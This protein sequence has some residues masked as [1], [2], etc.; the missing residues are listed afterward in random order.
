MSNTTDNTL[1]TALITVPQFK[2]EHTMS[3]AEMETK[4]SEGTLPRPFIFDGRRCFLRSEVEAALKY[5]KAVRRAIVKYGAH[6]GKPSQ[7]DKS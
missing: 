5:G 7:T 3:D 1:P 2:K 6:D 4:I